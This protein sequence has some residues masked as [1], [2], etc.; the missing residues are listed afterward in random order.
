MECAITLAKRGARVDLVEREPATG[1]SLAW[2]TR[3]PALGEWGRLGAYR[4]VQLK[5]LPGLT[6]TTGRELDAEQI[7][8]W[9]A[10]VVVLATGSSWARDGLNGFTRAPIAGADAAL[11]HVLTPEQLLLEGKRP[12]EGRVVVYDGDGYFAAAGI[13]ELL[14]RE[15]L[16]VELVT[17]YDSIAPFSAETLEDALTRRRLH[18]AGVSMRPA[19]TVTSIEP[20]RVT[21][22]SEFGDQQELAAGGIVLV[23]QRLSDDALYHQL[24]GRHPRVYRIG[25]CVAPRLLA[26]SVFDGHRMA[27]EIDGPDPEVALPFLRE[28]PMA[29]PPGPLQLAAPVGLAPRPA[30]APR[31]LELLEGSVDEVAARID[32]ALSDADEVV[33]AA[34]RGAGS[35]LAPFRMLAERLGARF[36]VSRPQVEAGRA[37]RAE[38]VGASSNTVAPAVYLALGI[39][40]AIPHLVGMSDSRLVIAVNS[41]RSARIFEHAD[42]GAVAD[43]AAVTLSIASRHS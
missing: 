38:L 13:A 19:T 18:E 27:R 11:P 25:D 14:A 30:P 41:D 43:A 8:A 26:E 20:G 9:G 5:R 22:E 36:V 37:T 17:G 6:L 2:I 12:P 10:D 15:G 1:G 33:V 42:L 16:E 24:D 39:S 34:G 35:D 29:D 28:R 31:R 23:T 40:G 4:A 7:E 3:L 21:I 32:Q